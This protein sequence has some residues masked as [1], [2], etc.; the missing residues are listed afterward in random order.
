MYF[1]FFRVTEG[2]LLDELSRLTDE[3]NRA[4]EEALKLSRKLG[5]TNFHVWSR[6]GLAGFVF[7]KEPDQKAWCRADRKT[8]L[9]WPRKNTV[10]G[11]A[12]WKEIKGLPPIPN[13]QKA[14]AIVGLDYSFPVI[15][16]DRN[17]YSPVAWG[18]VDKGVVFVKVPWR[19][20]DP[21][22]MEEYKAARA[23]GTR[24]SCM[25]DHLLWEPPSYMVEI[26]EW[27]MLKETEELKAAA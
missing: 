4:A 10:E 6:G 9:Y 7:E 5:A 2:E 17:G 25:L 21:A 12:I 11:K 22:E 23:K 27:E 1:R 18:W 15:C 20:I 14:L 8:G 16:D 24:M 26:K 19:D 13:V 3:R